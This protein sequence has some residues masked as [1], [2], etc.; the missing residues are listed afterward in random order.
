MGVQ[1]NQLILLCQQTADQL[2]WRILFY[3]LDTTT[4]SLFIPTT[5]NR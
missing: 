2:V 4:D 1:I 3:S 5:K